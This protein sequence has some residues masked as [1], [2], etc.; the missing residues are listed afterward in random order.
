MSS[1]LQG[2]LK[3]SSNPGGGVR[4]LFPKDCCP[5]YSDSTLSH[6]KDKCSQCM[7]ITYL[8]SECIGCDACP[9]GPL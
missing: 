7:V 3:K 6:R 4:M 9:T 1:G 5:A 8:A 2:G